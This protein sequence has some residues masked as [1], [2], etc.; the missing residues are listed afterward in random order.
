ME[1]GESEGCVCWGGGWL[2][3]EEGGDWR[4]GSRGW[5]ED[6]KKKGEADGV[7]VE[8]VD[9]DGLFLGEPIFFRV[10][11]KGRVL[12]LLGRLTVSGLFQ[13]L[14][15]IL[16]L[17]NTE[18]S[19]VLFCEKSKD[20]K[21]AGVCSSEVFD[22]NW[23]TCRLT[24]PPGALAPEWNLTLGCG[25]NEKNHKDGSKCEKPHITPHLGTVL[26]SNYWIKV[27]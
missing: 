11:R 23:V 21:K 13:L 22:W 10:S 5:T 17:R 20:G 25:E 2:V 6:D 12:I 4:R 19:G 27:T 3:G 16:G 7:V 14:P 26:N 1:F 8:A 18:S 9:N 15:Y 24:T